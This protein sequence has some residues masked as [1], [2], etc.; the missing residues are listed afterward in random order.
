MMEMGCSKQYL[1]KQ[2][3]SREASKNLSG[4]HPVSAIMEVCSKRKW[5]AP[6]FLLIRN[7]GP[8]HFR[9]FMFKVSY[10]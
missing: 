5:K 7:D 3:P 2:I 1:P 4:K 6:D 9:T 10:L 8:D